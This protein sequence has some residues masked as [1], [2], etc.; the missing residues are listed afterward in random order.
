MRTVNGKITAYLSEYHNLDELKEDEATS[1]INAVSFS[2]HDLT[3]NGYTVVGQAEI[4]LTI[5]AE[6]QLLLNKIASLTK[7][8]QCVLAE[9]QSTATRI[10]EKIQSLMAITYKPETE[11]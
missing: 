1:V 7:Q 4:T 8:K 10:D 5:L 11:A 3:T 9:A 2:M 6:D